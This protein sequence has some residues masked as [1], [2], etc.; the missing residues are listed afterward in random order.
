[1]VEL[2]LLWLAGLLAWPAVV[3]AASRLHLETERLRRL[4]V[5]SAVGL[6]GV[7][8]ALAFA[9]H[10]GS[11]LPNGPRGPAGFGVGPP[12][13]RIDALSEPL[14]AFAAL[15][16]L[17]TVA[18]T[19]RAALNRAGIGRTALATAATLVTFLTEQPLLLAAMW[20][21][22]IWIL[23]A[24]LAEPEHRIARRVA[25]V[26][27]GFSAVLFVAG[28][29]LLSLPARADGGARSAGILLV[30]AAVLIRNGSLPV[31]SW[32]PEVFER[33]RLGPAALFSAPQAG[34]YATAVLIV[35]GASDAVLRTAALLALATCV[36]GAAL[37]LVQDEPRRAFGY[38]FLSQSAL[39]MA[40]L[41]CTSG[42]ALAGGLCLWLSSGVAFAGLARCLLVVEARRGRL[43][44]ARLNGGY[45]WMPLLAASFLLLGLAC[46]G[47]PGT[48]GY[49][50][51]ELLVDGAV[52][53]LPLV[54]FSVIVAGALTGLA[55]LR[56][57]FALFC[58]RH[59]ASP[60]L[61]L[62]PR[63]RIVFTALATILL[64]LGLAPQ[65]LV[66][67][68][69]LAAAQI[70]LRRARTPEDP[71]LRSPL[72][73]DAAHEQRHDQ[74][75]GDQPVRDEDRDQAAVGEGALVTEVLRVDPGRA[76]EEHRPAHRR[77]DEVGPAIPQR[78]QREDRHPEHGHGGEVLERA[79][80]GEAVHPGE[81]LRIRQAEEAGGQHG[82][83][84][85]A[86]EDVEHRDLADPSRGSFLEEHGVDRHGHERCSQ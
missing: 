63:E 70:L 35:P 62:L 74:E 47:F 43:S 16:W 44:L 84:A 34:A 9:A 81:A 40:G 20:V 19:P 64:V 75:H 31:H 80:G 71:E 49:V 26:H 69:R 54:G 61:K 56:M 21:A 72:L 42:D 67:S 27:L 83:P 85:V 48:L 29:V 68:R 12:L 24:G 17:V 82:H 78:Q 60:H 53:K 30:V 8:V 50:A 79:P 11:A 52:T 3:V 38:L 28:A 46:T 7:S 65:P 58:G 76:A 86:R 32:V 73:P 59:E 4:A 2:P 23:L 13:L 22:S 10:T 6:L 1:V 18:V 45:E 55:V 77:G 15:L 57:Y 51:A 39:V 66:E 5:V 25:A 37:A 41:D 36:Y 33:G 14:P